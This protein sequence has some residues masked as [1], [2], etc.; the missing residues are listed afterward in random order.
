M[1]VNKFTGATS[2][3][4]SDATNWSL[5]TVPTTTDGHDTTFDATSPSC[6][7][8]ANVGCNHIIMTGYAATFATGGNIFTV[9]GNITLGGTISMTSTGQWSQTSTGTLTSNGVALS[10]FLVLQ[11]STGT[12]TLADDWTVGTLRLGVTASFTVNG[13]K[14]YAT[15]VQHQ[16]NTNITGTTEIV[17]SGSGGTISSNTTSNFS[18]QLDTTI[19][20]AGTVT[21]SNFRFGTKTLKYVSGTFSHT[22]T[23]S[24]V[25]S[26][27]TLDFAGASFNNVTITTASTVTLNGAL[28]GAGTLTLPN[29][30]VAFAGAFGFSFPTITNTAITANRSYS[31]KD[32]VTYLATNSLT[33]N[34]TS[35][36]TLTVQSS[37][38]TIKA[39]LRLTT[40]KTQDIKYVSATRID[41][42]G[43]ETLYTFGSRALLDTINWGKREGSF[44][45]FL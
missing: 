17:V 33:L 42:S 29:G 27:C 43:G 2:N 15:S 19:N 4:W 3:A 44:F 28:N 21:M 14:I 5:G 6:A 18:V 16:N 23:L 9:S 8:A 31:F 39:V 11:T 12:R 41:S 10:G 38:A 13:Y 37:S 20:S 36:S 26:T 24:I 35:T 7:I 25:N 34:G 40:G 1:A 45:T 32:G 30:N 22:G